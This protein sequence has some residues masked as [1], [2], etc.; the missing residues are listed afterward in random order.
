MNRQI[1]HL[2]LGFVALW[3][4]ITTIVGTSAILGT[5]LLQMFISILFGAIIS[6]LLIHTIPIMRN[7]RED[8]LTTGAKFLWFLALVYDLY[9]AYNGNKEYITNKSTTSAQ[10]I[11]TMGLTI[12]VASAPIAISWILFDEN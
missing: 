4:A 6:M 5:G 9:T 3:D 2:F 7:P 8:L 12:F 11:I 10:T 1:L